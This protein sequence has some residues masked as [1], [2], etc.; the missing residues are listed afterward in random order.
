MAMS[1]VPINKSLTRPH[2][3]IH[4]LMQSGGLVAPSWPTNSYSFK[5]ATRAEWSKSPHT[6]AAPPSLAPD[7][8]H[9][10]F[11]CMLYEWLTGGCYDC[12]RETPLVNH[13]TRTHTHTQVHH[14]ETCRH[15]D[16][17]AP[18]FVRMQS[19]KMQNPVCVG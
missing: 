13:N 8:S 16:T 15:R 2:T 9:S 10:L 14:P 18:S 7:T 6:P 12:S 19:P 17:P 11:S 4:A 3:H 1:P 5:T